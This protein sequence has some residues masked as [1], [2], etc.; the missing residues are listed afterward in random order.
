MRDFLLKSK[1]FRTFGLFLLFFL[2]LLATVLF[3]S[4]LQAGVLPPGVPGEWQWQKPNT[5]MTMNEWFWGIF[6]LLTY[7]LIT[8]LLGLFA[9]GN[10]IRQRLAL[11][12]LLP[13]AGLVQ[14]GL[15]MGAPSTFGLAKWAMCTFYPAASGYFTVA[16]TEVDNLPEFLENYPNWI[17]QQDS[18]H[19][20]THPPGL[21]VE[22]KWWLNFWEARPQ[23]SKAF[24]NLLF[25]ELRQAIYQIV[26]GRKFPDWYLAAIVSIST[27]HWFLCALTVWPL[28][29]M[30]QRLGFSFHTSWSIAAIW[31]VV[32]SAVMFQPASDIAFPVLL[33]TAIFLSLDS[34]ESVASFSRLILESLVCGLILSFGMFLSLVFLPIGLIVGLTLMFLSKRK[35]KQRLLRVTAVGVGFI[36]GTLL[37]GILSKSNPLMIWYYNQINHGRFYDEYPRS[38]LKWII[39]DLMEV[40]FGFGLPLTTLLLISLFFI[41]LVKHQKSSAFR[42]FLMTVSTLAFLMF[43]GKSLS[44]VSRLWLPF[45]P[46]LTI[47]VAILFESRNSAIPLLRSS[48]L[49]LLMIQIL[50]MQTFIQVVYSF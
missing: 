14:I 27:T 47:P 20:G 8:A 50:W 31:P 40:A 17:K 29:M 11:V 46:L 48:T 42:L 33:C 41:W 49:L 18:L 36:F 43:S 35:W 2:P 26:P 22:A 13:C 5:Q 9:T 21:I 6:S 37:W 39:A 32:P 16:I 45:M 10:K 19:I 4:L 7:L 1:F 34:D 24:L 28:W 3:V 38:Y 23:F 30:L 15:Q 12:S 25:G 44:E